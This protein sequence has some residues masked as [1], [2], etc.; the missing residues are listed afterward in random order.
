M[1]KKKI[2]NENETAMIQEAKDRHYN[3]TNKS[4]ALCNNNL[5][6]KGKKM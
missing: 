6:V 1:K 4:T 2:Y 3:S 5:H